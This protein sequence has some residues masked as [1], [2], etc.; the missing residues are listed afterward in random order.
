MARNCGSK[1]NRE[2]LIED[3]INAITEFSNSSSQTLRIDALSECLHNAEVPSNID[4]DDKNAIMKQY[5]FYFAFENQ[6]EEDYITEKLWG[7]LEAGTIPVYFGAP[8]IIDHVPNHSIINV[9]DFN[10]TIEL[11]EYLIQEIGRAHV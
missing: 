3:M 6:C 1:N 8:N 11:I 2:L 10:T 9:F 5:L 4:L 7:P